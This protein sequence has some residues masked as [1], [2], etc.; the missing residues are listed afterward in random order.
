MGCDEWGSALTDWALDELPPTAAE[1][2]EQHLALCAECSRSAAQL[3]E[4]RQALRSNLTERPLP[5]HLVFV[6]EKRKPIFAGFWPVLVRAAALSAAAAAVFLGIV[7]LGLQYGP[8]R[9]LLAGAGPQPALTQKAV[10]T[11]VERAVAAQSSSQQQRVRAATEEMAESL[12]Q[13]EMGN[14]ARLAQQLQYL[15]LAQN[16]VWR[17]TQ[18]QD[19]V[20]R[21][22]ARTGLESAGSVSPGGKANVVDQ[23]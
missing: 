7:S 6:G 10:E 4:L 20:L 5:A 3:R 23:R 12:R 1:R 16:T 22:V 17:E 21:L 19:K 11:M 15:E 13:E 14:W 2:L 9:G 8:S 18:E